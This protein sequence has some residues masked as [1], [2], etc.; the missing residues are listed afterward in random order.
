MLIKSLY[1]GH[2]NAFHYFFRNSLK[3]YQYVTYIKTPLLL[4]EHSHN[5]ETNMNKTIKMENETIAARSEA[6]KKKHN[7]DNKTY[8]MRWMR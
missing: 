2:I 4:F 7:N 5:I 8:M 6:K 1:D 3:M